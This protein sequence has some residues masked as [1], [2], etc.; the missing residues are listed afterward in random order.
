[1]REAGNDFRRTLYPPSQ[2][3]CWN[4]TAAAGK[5][6]HPRQPR[7]TPPPRE[8]FVHEH[9]TQYRQQRCGALPF[10]GAA[11]HCVEPGWR[12]YSHGAGMHVG[13]RCTYRR[14]QGRSA[15]PWVPAQLKVSFRKSRFQ[16]PRGQQPHSAARPPPRS[17]RHRVA[18]VK[19]SA[20]QAIGSPPCLY[21]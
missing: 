5:R 12:A 7:T 16:S 18:Y 14:Q 10:S 11:V 15:E 1:M 17:S 3:T 6:H 8:T 21:T 2:R 9:S 19:V 20:R 4:F 13:G